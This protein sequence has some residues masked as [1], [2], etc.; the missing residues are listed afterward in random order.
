MCT[1][2]GGGG[3]SCLFGAI[4]SFKSPNLANQMQYISI[5]ENGWAWGGKR[6]V[7]HHFT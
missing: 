1:G 4:M 2:G 7:S 6:E 5:L 3:V